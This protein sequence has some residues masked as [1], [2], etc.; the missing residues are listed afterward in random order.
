MASLHLRSG[1]SVTFLDQKRPAATPLCCT[2]AQRLAGKIPGRA[3]LD[4]YPGPGVM[5]EYFGVRDVP[6]RLESQN[7]ERRGI[8]GIHGLREGLDRWE[9]T[10]N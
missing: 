5:A 9:R 6:S 1:L 8:L 3:C 10:Y 4:R 7:G 2:Q